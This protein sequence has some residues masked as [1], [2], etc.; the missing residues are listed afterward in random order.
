M[1]VY[2]AWARWSPWQAYRHGYTLGRWSGVALYLCPAHAGLVEVEEPAHPFPIPTRGGLH[3]P[4]ASTGASILKM[5][6]VMRSSRHCCSRCPSSTLGRTIVRGGKAR[7]LASLRGGRPPGHRASGPRAS[8]PV[9]AKPG[10]DGS[11]DICMAGTPNSRPY[12]LGTVR[13]V[14]TSGVLVVKMSS[15]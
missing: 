12:R 15:C 6:F 9:G 4:R 14:L 5:I 13:H 1:L 8:P 2:W 7:R 10:G 11:G 3:N